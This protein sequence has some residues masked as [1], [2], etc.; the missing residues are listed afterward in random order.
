MLD[1]TIL[2][3]YDIRGVV[4]QTLTV[5]GVRAIG[6]AFGT[7][8]VREQGRSVAV[9]YDG[10]LSSPML[11]AA[12]V[13]GLASTG[14]AVYRIGLGPTPMLYF[15][16]KHLGADGGMMITGSHNPPDYNG[17]KMLKAGKAFFGDD[18]ARLG[19][20][21]ADGDVVSGAG[22]VEQRDVSNAYIARLAQD[23]GPG[24]P[25]SVAWDPGN[26][27]AGAVLRALCDRLPGRHI[28]INETVDGTFPAHHPDPT[29]EE[30]LE[31]LKHAVAEHGCD[32]GIGLDGDGDRIGVIDETGTVVWGDQ[33]LIILAR[34]ILA[35]LPGSTIIADVK[36]S[37]VFFD[38]IERLGGKALMSR[39]GHSL[40][41]NL[42]TQTGA[43]L[44]GEMSGHIFFAHRYYGYDDALYAAVRL[45]SVAAASDVGIAGMLQALPAMVNTPE[46]RIDCPD[47]RKFGVIEE[48]RKRLK[49]VA[50]ITVQDIDGVRVN[51][52]DGWWL[53]R[54]SNT[55][56]VLVG[57][58][59]AASKDGLDRLKRQLA[60][61]LSRSD[62][63]A[64]AV[65]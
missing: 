34:P 3:E 11:E 8:V 10:R 19:R 55:Q 14:L 65:G 45:L 27:A 43:P 41:K 53:L 38:E 37:Q 56:P 32:L 50:G 48:V 7:L 24:R 52:A 21:V 46:L 35:E 57:R 22:T 29:V 30:N 5:D 25:L 18:I 23:M 54:A 12:L 4:G 60:D 63:D 47:A 59:E 6:R 42:L 13:E 9:G 36:S 17:I 40:I 33:L 58:C 44:A 51:T 31:D 64:H 16:A 26:G 28:I 49:G 2:R 20:M 62:V 15:A 39:T 61:Q 1:P